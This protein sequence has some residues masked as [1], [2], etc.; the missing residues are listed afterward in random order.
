MIRFFF[1]LFLLSA[2]AEAAPGI[3]SFYGQSESFWRYY[4]DLSEESSTAENNR[5]LIRGLQRN[6]EL[7]FGRFNFH[8]DK[9]LDNQADTDWPNRFHFTIEGEGASIVSAQ[10]F[11]LNEIRMARFYG[12]VFKGSYQGNI[13]EDL[14]FEMGFAFGAGDQ[15]KV[16]IEDTAGVQRSG[17]ATGTTLLGGLDFKLQK[18]WRLGVT[19]LIN[20][21]E[22]EETYFKTLNERLVGDLT[23]DLRDI[24]HD[25]SFRTDY[26]F[27]QM[28]LHG[29]IA[30]HPYPTLLLP[31]SWNR[32]ASV[33]ASSRPLR[34]LLGGGG[35]FTLFL[36]PDVQMAAL[37]GYYAGA[38]GGEL[39]FRFAKTVTLRASAYNVENSSDYQS[40]TQR[41]YAAGLE[42]AL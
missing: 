13:A 30:A 21:L 4:K 34:S 39:R 32:V 16:M 3:L 1:T 31:R 42:I 12:G 23:W 7:A 8:S 33:S 36:G 22:T 24:S 9:R 2:Q 40:L 19:R 6:Y 38:L 18:I 5:T 28:N 41:V 10:G 29:I 25:W 11:S 37:G 14:Y 20:T 15:I 17:R 27:S 35:G 26:M